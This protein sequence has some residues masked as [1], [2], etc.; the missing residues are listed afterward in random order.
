MSSNKTNSSTPRR[1]TY[2]NGFSN[3]MNTIHNVSNKKPT[4]EQNSIK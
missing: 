2:S 4:N 1:Q 3:L